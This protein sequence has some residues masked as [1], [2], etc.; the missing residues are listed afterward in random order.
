MPEILVNISGKSTNTT[1]NEKEKSQKSHFPKGWI[2]LNAKRPKKPDFKKATP[3]N[4]GCLCQGARCQQVAGAQEQSS[5][6]LR[7]T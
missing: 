3:R 2:G 7:S 4:P 1:E 5:L 6:S